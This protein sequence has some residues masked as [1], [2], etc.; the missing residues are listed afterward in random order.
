MTFWGETEHFSVKRWSIKE[1]HFSGEI[2]SI[3]YK[4]KVCIRAKWPIRLELI[5]KRLRVFLLPLGWDA[6]PSLG[7]VWVNSKTTHAPP[8]P[9]ANPRAFD[10]FEKFWSNFPLCCQFRRS[11]APPIR[12]SKRV[13]TPPSSH[14]KA[15]VETSCA[16]F[17]ATMNFLFSL[18]LLHALNKGIF[19]D[20][21]I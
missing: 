10:F 16:K 8:P 17:S 18:S 3:M 5:M 11:N 20:I 13:N 1:E 14:V 9:R 21:T 19:H 4:G 12:A 6:S 2:K 7:Y 15:T